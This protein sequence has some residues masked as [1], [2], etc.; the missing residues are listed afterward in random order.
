MTAQHTVVDNVDFGFT[1]NLLKSNLDIFEVP[2]EHIE[3]RKGRPTSKQ[4]KPVEKPVEKRGKALE[5]VKTEAEAPALITLEHE[6]FTL[7]YPP[8]EE[9]DGDVFEL[10]EDGQMISCVRL[11][12]GAE[13]WEKFKDHLRKKNGKYR[14][15]DAAAVYVAILSNMGFADSGE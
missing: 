7:T 1:T 13:Q 15:P 9:W 2:V 8:A 10:Q 6:G 4:V 11:I 3:A 14:G 12:L 5:A